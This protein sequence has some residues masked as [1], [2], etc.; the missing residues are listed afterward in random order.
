MAVH[1]RYNS[2]YIPLP[3][4]AKQ[5]REIIKFCIV[6]SNLLMCPSLSF[7]MALTKINKVNDVRVPRDSQVKY[8]LF[9]IDVVLGITVV[10]S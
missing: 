8:K 2:W 10:V 7:A 6:F 3:S 5:Q 9:L 1:V 4:T